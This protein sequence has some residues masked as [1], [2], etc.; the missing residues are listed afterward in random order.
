[1][2]QLNAKGKTI[3]FVTHESDI[4]VF[5]GRTIMLRDGHIIKDELITPQSAKA[6][7]EA[8]P[9]SDDY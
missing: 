7:L 9:A 6:A 2:Q 8:L 5:T 3:A 1:F 4:A